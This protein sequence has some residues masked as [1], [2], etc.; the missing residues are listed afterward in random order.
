ME[1][2]WIISLLFLIAIQCVLSAELH[3]VRTERAAKRKGKDC[4]PWVFEECKAKKGNC[5][6]GKKVGRRSGAD[7]GKTEKVFPCTVPCDGQVGGG[8]SPN[9]AKNKRGGDKI[10]KYTR[11]DWSN[12]DPTTNQKTRTLTLRKGD[13][14]SCEKEKKITKSCKRG[15]QVCQYDKG[16]WS[17]C[18]PTTK[19]KERTLTLKDGS[20][21]SCPATKPQSRECKG[22]NKD[23]CFFGPWGEFSECQNGV[24]KKQR[25]LKY[26]GAECQKRAVKTKPC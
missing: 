2:K 22:E 16:D 18:D 26:G 15:H 7:C 12:C 13:P 5:G 6:G 25:E 21:A 17:E 8:D 14:N 1:Y 9:M 19:T 3:G 20:D 4:T 10:C 24:R 11:G 23:R